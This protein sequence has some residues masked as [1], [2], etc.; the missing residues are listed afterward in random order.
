M[1][2]CS[3]ASAIAGLISDHT[4]AASITPAANPWDALRS[5]ELTFE[6]VSTSDAPNNVN[7]HVK[8]VASRA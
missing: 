8:I 7:D 5:L 3:S 4:L 6:T 1:P 2:P